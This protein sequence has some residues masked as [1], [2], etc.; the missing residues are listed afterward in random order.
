MK[1]ATMDLN[2]STCNNNLR[3][4][5]FKIRMELA[6]FL[7]FMASVLR[8][9]NLV[10]VTTVQI[11]KEFNSKIA[12]CVN[13]SNLEMVPKAR[14]CGECNAFVVKKDLL[15]RF[16]PYMSMGDGDRG[17]LSNGVVKKVLKLKKGSFE[18]SLI[19]SDWYKLVSDLAH[20]LTDFGELVEPINRPKSLEEELKGLSLIPPEGDEQV[21]LMDPI[22]KEGNMSPLDYYDPFAPG[23]ANMW[24]EPLYGDL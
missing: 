15:K 21:R 20:F 1:S 7:G 4:I 5:P 19:K 12:S 3:G 2:S 10:K 22:V 6:E 8:T 14:L 18:F 11:P 9:T 24:R 17:A 23:P 16:A 13:C